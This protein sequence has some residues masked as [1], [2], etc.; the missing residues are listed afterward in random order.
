VDKVGVILAA[1]G[2][3]E[4]FGAEVPKQFLELR[5]RPVFWWSLRVFEAHPGVGEIVARMVAKSNF[6]DT[7]HPDSCWL[8]IFSDDLLLLLW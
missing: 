3:G 5:G 1:A 8:A 7:S 4:R 6:N 2:R